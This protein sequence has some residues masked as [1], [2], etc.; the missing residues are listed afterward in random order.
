MAVFLV[1]GTASTQA[2][3][4]DNVCHNTSSGTNPWVAQ[5]VNANQLQSHLDNG[6]FLYLGPV[7]NDGKFIDKETGDQWCK[8]NVP[9]ATPTPT[10]SASPTPD[11][12]PTVT[13]T[14]TPS[15]TSTPTPTV[16]VSPTP[17]LTPTPTV[18]PTPTPTPTVQAGGSI[19]EAPGDQG[20]GGDCCK[21]DDEQNVTVSKKAGQVLGAKEGEDKTALKTVLALADTGAAGALLP[22]G[23]SLAGLV[24]MAISKSKLRS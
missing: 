6:D 17:T 1:F 16:S 10:P 18:S 9:T 11:V 21:H 12:S 5:Q 3:D 22:M 23:T 14:A 2:V 8:D 15:P 20:P 19:V 24:L 7:D 4:K 13:P